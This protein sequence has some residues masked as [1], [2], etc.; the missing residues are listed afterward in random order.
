MKDPYAILDLPH[1]STIEQIKA[2][3]RKLCLKYHPDVNPSHEEK[4]K[5]I[6]IAYKTL[7]EKTNIKSWSVSSTIFYRFLG[8]YTR[9]ISIPVPNPLEEDVTIYCM[10][11]NGREIRITLT[12]GTQFPNHIRIK[13]YN[14]LELVINNE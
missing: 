3:Y 14:D 10:I 5:E 9:N 12:K 2:Q 8:K 13:N 1:S 11:D 7:I 6:T 4:F